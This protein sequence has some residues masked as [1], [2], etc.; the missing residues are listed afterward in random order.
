MANSPERVHTVK[1]PLPP[2]AAG[3]CP[4]LFRRMEAK[5]ELGRSFE[6]TVDLVCERDDVNPNDL[7]GK[8]MA[9]GVRM[10]GDSGKGHET[11]YFHGVVGSFS[12]RGR[13]GGYAVYRAVLRPWVWLLSHNYDCRIFQDMTVLQIFEAVCKTRHGFADFRLATNEQYRTREYCVQYRESDFAFVSRLLEEEGV[14]YFFEHTEDKHTL[15][16]ADANSAFPDVVGPKEI[17]YRAAGEGRVELEHVSEWRAQFEVR[18]GS[19]VLDDYDFTKPRV[20]LQGTSAISR[21]HSQSEFETYDYPG[22]HSETADG[23]ALARLRVEEIQSRHRRVAGI[24]DHRGLTPGGV[25]KLTEHHRAAENAEYAVVTTEI[26][27]ESAEIEQLRAG[28]ENTFEAKFEAIPKPEPFRPQRLTPKP[29]VRGPQTAVVVG[30]QGEEIWTDKYA[31]V[32][33]QFH[34]DREGQSDENSSCWV[35]VSQSWAGKNWGAIQT[36]RIGQEVVVDFLEGDPDRPLV[37]G[38]VYNDGQMPPYDLPD[39]QTQ[40]GV[41]S[42]STKEGSPENFNELRFEDKIDEEHVYFHAERDFERVVENDDVLRVGFEKKSP[43]S[44]TIEVYKNRTA[45][46]KTGNDGITVAQGNHSIKVTAGESLIEA[47]TK[48]TLKVGASTI[49][50]E[51]A[52]ITLNSPEIAITGTA[53]VG[54]SAPMTEASGSATLSL[55]GGIVKIN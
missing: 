35:R 40:S 18:S 11:R 23:G 1:C 49:T 38:R 45:E 19:V 5:E 32:K 25:F 30:K 55:T 51:P 54:V 20:D 31:R 48:I 4:L 39:N 47:A 27:V 28:A 9:V 41:K 10:P 17:P 21:S 36:P 6:Y 15:V 7:L 8:P 42:R 33:L 53:K 37:T 50:I 26:K 14:F 24:G 29:F 43:G 2:N 12:Y 3:E 22:L 16:L 46:I 13:E 52:K 34:W 44:Q